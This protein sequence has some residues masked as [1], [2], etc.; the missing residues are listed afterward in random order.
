ML[1]GQHEVVKVQ[2]KKRTL[3]SLS[4]GRVQRAIYQER[5]H[6]FTCVTLVNFLPSLTSGL[7]GTETQCFQLKEQIQ[8]SGMNMHYLSIAMLVYNT[9]VTICSSLMRI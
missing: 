6:Q 8:L 9:R 7:V 2:N 5:L 3:F 1:Q 4:P